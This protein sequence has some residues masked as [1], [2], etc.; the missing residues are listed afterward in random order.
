[1]TE[2]ALVIFSLFDTFLCIFLNIRREREREPSCFGEQDVIHSI[3]PKI[4]D[5]A[6]I[7]IFKTNELTMTMPAHV[8]LTDIKYIFLRA[9]TSI[10]FVGLTMVLI[11][12]RYMLY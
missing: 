10:L 9:V 4:K 8:Q 7:E 5:F 1:M 6:E 3:F 2:G 11:G 12:L